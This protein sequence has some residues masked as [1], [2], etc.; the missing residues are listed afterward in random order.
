MSN[1]HFW[2][3][4]QISSNGFSSNARTIDFHR[5]YFRK[6]TPTKRKERLHCSF[7][8]SL[9]DFFRHKGDSTS[10]GELRGGKKISLQWIHQSVYLSQM[11]VVQ[12]PMCATGG[13]KRESVV[14]AN[15]HALEKYGNQLAGHQMDA[16]THTH[17]TP[18]SSLRSLVSTVTEDKKGGPGTAGLQ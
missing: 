12:L 15:G 17:T 14:T 18:C 11:S 2:D 6:Q 10:D 16:H 3:D 8:H 9:W 13:N 1:G 5:S 4:A 7:S